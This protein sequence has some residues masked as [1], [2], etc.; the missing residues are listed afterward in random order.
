MSAYEVV[1][2][3]PDTPEW[4]E[5]RRTSIGASEVA[6]VMGL[7]KWATP[8][9]VYK[10]KH[11]VDRPIDVERAFWGHE[12]ETGLHNW[13]EQLSGID[14]RLE[15]GFMARSVEVPYLHATFDRVSYSPFLTWQFKTSSA[16]AGH[17]W[18]EGIPTDIRVQVQAEMFVAGTQRAAVV[19]VIDWKA[20]LFWEA[21]DDQ[22]I[23]EQM[24]PALD[25][26]WARVRAQN[27]PEP[28]TIAEAAEVWPSEDRSVEASELAMEAVE[29]RAVLLSDIQAQQEEADALK[30]VIAQ[31]META[32]T[33][34]FEGRK[35][36]T[37]KTQKG[38][39]G[40]DREAL[41]RDHPDIVAS[42]TRQGS[43][44]RVMRTIPPKGSR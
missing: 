6:A 42:Y 23:Q 39:M 44:F 2:V 3:T 41:E 31:Y 1:N 10:A 32:D 26:A 17:Q 13:V 5:E 8:L 22:F 4:E 40:L 28:T 15:P 16:Y 30:L 9:D 25:E 33:L 12:A 18:D 19:V 38:R 21:R 43:P 24:L 36:L 7:S 14:V 34:T 29:R 37:Y 35:V 11:G 20:R 27:P